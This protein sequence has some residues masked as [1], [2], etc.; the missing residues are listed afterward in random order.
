MERGKKIVLPII[1]GLT[2]LALMTVYIKRDFI[3]SSYYLIKA[4]NYESKNEIQKSITEI[5]RALGFAPDSS[6]IRWVLVRRYISLGRYDEALEEYK[7]LV[8]QHPNYA[9]GYTGLAYCYAIR[10]DREAAL[11]NYRKAAE[12]DPK[13][14]ENFYNIVY[15][16]YKSERLEDAIESFK[17][18]IALKPDHPKANLFLT[19]ALKKLEGKRK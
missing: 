3:F 9:G 5:E 7:W 10:G 16:L 19:K 11:A 6:Y 1:L 15:V 4:R 17:K 14:P 18:A 13:N 12:L 2:A 8:R